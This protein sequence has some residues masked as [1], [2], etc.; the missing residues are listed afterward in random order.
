MNYSQ[1]NITDDHSLNIALAIDHCKKNNIDTLTFDN[2]TYL[3]KPQMASER[4]CSISNHDVHE[5][6]SIGMLIEDMENF[7][8]DANGSTFICDGVMLSCAILNSKNI[9]LKNMTLEA[10]QHL[11]AEARVLEIGENSFIFEMTGDTGYYVKNGMLYLTNDYGHDDMFHYY[12]V[13]CREGDESGYIPETVE[14]FKKAVVFEDLG[15]NRIS[16]KDAQYVP[17][18]GSR[19]LLAPALRHGTTVFAEK[20]KN[21][22]LENVTVHTSY[23]MAVLAQMCENFYIDKLSVKAK[24]GLLHTT[25]NDATHFVHCSG[26]VK[27]TNSYFEAMLDDALNVHG[28]YN[29]VEHVDDKGILVRDMHPGSKGIDIYRAG[30]HIAVMDQKLLI[31]MATYTIDDAV[32]VNSEYFYLTLREGTKG[33]TRGLVCEELDHSP[34]VI[35]ENNTVQNNRARGMLL[36]S[37]GKTVV[38]NNYFHTPGISVMLE[39]SGDFWFEA[40]N[41]EDIVIENNVFDNCGYAL[42][43]WGK[44]VIEIVARKAF[45]GENYYHKNITVVNNEF[46]NNVRPLIIAGNVENVTF[47]DNKITNTVAP[48]Q[49]VNCK[50]VIDEL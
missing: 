2:G 11:R 47:K 32:M 41:T 7:T 26:L 13:V 14:S 6:T 43:A 48:N 23:G 45:D 27:I 16:I 37:H 17:A 1:F 5:F 18:V 22:F 15:N 49:Y 34:N 29:L 44:A 8:I 36:A 31:P 21:I 50:N 24:G 33:I 35:F 25:N 4:A 19:I 38:R 28:L 20:S 30:C 3:L 12:I 39:S 40:G 42:G 10:R 46:K 9:T